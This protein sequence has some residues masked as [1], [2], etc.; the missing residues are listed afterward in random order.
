MSAHFHKGGLLELLRHAYDQPAWHG[1]NLRE[2]LT[3][4]TLSQALWRPAPERRNVWELVLHC[5]YWKHVVVR[6]LEGFGD[7][8]GFSRS[9]ADFPALPEV[10]QVAWASDLALLEHTHQQLL[11]RVGELDAARLAEPATAK[12]NRTLAEIVFGVAHHDIYHAGQIRLLL[13]LQGA[14]A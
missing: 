12:E 11:T 3:G 14:S 13:A 1:A 2:S 9:P 4:V 7:D 6:R 10:T 8:S 5:A